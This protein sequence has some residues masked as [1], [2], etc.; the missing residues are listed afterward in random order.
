MVLVQIVELGEA[1]A[2]LHTQLAESEEQAARHTTRLEQRLR[3][4]EDEAE[5]ARAKIPI[6]Q[7]DLA[8][9]HQVLS[10]VYCTTDVMFDRTFHL[11]AHR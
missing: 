1:A 3:D 11:M 7:A 9:S 8:A 10:W 5:A 6:L 4:A 2:M